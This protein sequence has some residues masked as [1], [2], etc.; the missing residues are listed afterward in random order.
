MIGINSDSISN[1]IDRG[2]VLFDPEK[3]TNEYSLEE[4]KKILV[5]NNL[6]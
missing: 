6:I 4:V 1:L 3:I 2:Y 5:K